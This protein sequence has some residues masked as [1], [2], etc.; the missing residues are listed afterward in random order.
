MIT[1]IAQIDIKPGQEE[2]FEAAVAK[3]RPLFATAKGSIELELLRSIEKPSR[4]RLH[5]KWETLESHIVDFRGSPA[6]TEWRALIGPFLVSAPE[7]EHVE[8][9]MKF[10]N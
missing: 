3:A 9:V 4:Y 6:F 8:T 1:E 10:V 2:S 7:V 5:A